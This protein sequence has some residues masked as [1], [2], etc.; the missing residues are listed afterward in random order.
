MG[1]INDIVA[2]SCRKVQNLF[3]EFMYFLG[4]YDEDDDE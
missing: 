3:E 2:T 1:K 4:V